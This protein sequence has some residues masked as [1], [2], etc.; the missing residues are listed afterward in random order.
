LP[1][2]MR[3]C[4]QRLLCNLHEIRQGRNTEGEKT[5]EG[6]SL[7]LTPV[8]M[9]LSLRLRPHLPPF[10]S[11]AI[12]TVLRPLC[13]GHPRNAPVESELRK[14]MFRGTPCC[15]GN[16]QHASR[17][18]YGAP[19][20]QLGTTAMEH[21][22]WHARSVPR[23]HDYVQPVQHVVQ[24]NQHVLQPKVHVVHRVHAFI[25]RKGW[26]PFFPHLS[27]IALFERFFRLKLKQNGFIT[28]YI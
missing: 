2:L 14:A 23:V 22:A 27:K 11:S 7:P 17:A 9:S 12:A 25:L 4:F 16:K 1:P 20:P 28:P 18:T 21:R 13:G 10:G 15:L 8:D 3:L 6:G 26:R 19:N 24:R 5:K